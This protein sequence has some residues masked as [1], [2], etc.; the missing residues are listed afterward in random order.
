MIIEI[1]NL[2]NKV[3]VNKNRLKEL[4]ESVLKSMDESDAELSV[5]VSDDGYIKKLNKKYRNKN[6]ATDVLAFSAREGVNPRAESSVLGDVVI[7]AETAK[8]EAEKRKIS[9]H[10]EMSLYLIHGILHLLGYDDAK[11][12]ERE[13]MRAKE[14]ELMEGNSRRLSF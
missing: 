12:A 10:E 13:I 2:Q 14:N 1:L 5:L 3:R 8:R 7:S 9:F 11:A 4:A 6:A